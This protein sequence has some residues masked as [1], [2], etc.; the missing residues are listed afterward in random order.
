[1]EVVEAASA[2]DALEILRGR[3]NVGVLLTDINMPG[4]LDGM[5]LARMVH[6]RWPAIQLVVTSGR[7]LPDAV[8]DDGAFLSKPYTLDDM[9][10]TV[11]RMAKRGD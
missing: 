7:A 4:A 1:M 11:T 8:P 2:E 5:D 10:E 3:S 9:T 6:E